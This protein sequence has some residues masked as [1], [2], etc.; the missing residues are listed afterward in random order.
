VAVALRAR[1][2]RVCR[3]VAAQ[4]TGDA[5]SQPAPWY[6]LSTRS[7]RKSGLRWRVFKSVPYFPREDAAPARRKGAG[8][9]QN[10]MRAGPK[11]GVHAK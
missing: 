6:I 8:Q 7:G 4:V 5:T 10:V 1:G 3:H 2:S 11:S 9:E